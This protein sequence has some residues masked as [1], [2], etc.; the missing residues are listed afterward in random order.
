[1]RRRDFLRLTG[2]A[3]SAVV[4]P[5]WAKPELPLVIW[6]SYGDEKTVGSYHAAVQKGLRERGLVD[7]QTIRFESYF[8]QFSKERVQQLIPEIIAKTARRG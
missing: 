8:A 5:A 2:F 7:G 4:L 6:F 3:A 1:M